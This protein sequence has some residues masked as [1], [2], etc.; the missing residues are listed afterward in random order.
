MLRKYVL[1]LMLCLFSTALFAEQPTE[2]IRKVYS[3]LRKYDQT[4]PNAAL[5]KS[6]INNHFS[7]NVMARAAIRDHYASMNNRQQKEYM[8]LMYQLLEKAVYQDTQENLRKGRVRFTGERRQSDRAKVMTNIFIK[9]EDMEI[10]ND[11]MLRKNSETWRVYDIYIDGASLVEDYRSQF[12][13]IIAENG[14]DKNEN[15]LFP[16]LRN[17]LKEDKD[18]WRKNWKSKK[19]KRDKVTPTKRPS[20]LDNL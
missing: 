17:A 4:A 8:Q 13:Q 14:V 18:E 3:L 1:T 11:F 10:D 5:T 7:L 2:V 12:N 20:I 16:R 15:S 19:E 6:Q 9:D